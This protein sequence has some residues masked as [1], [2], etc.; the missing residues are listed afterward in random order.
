MEAQD[1]LKANQC[2][3]NCVASEK[4]CDRWLVLRFVIV[5]P[6]AILPA[7]PLCIY[8]TFQEHAGAILRVT[9]SFVQ[10]PLDCEASVQSHA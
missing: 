3:V 6:L 7:V 9:S 10:C 5:E 2:G 4:L 1:R 8:H